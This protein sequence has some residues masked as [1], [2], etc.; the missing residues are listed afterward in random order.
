MIDGILFV[1][2][3]LL[4][5]GSIQCPI[6]QLKL[7]HNY[8]SDNLYSLFGGER[9]VQIDKIHEIVSVCKRRHSLRAAAIKNR[10]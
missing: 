5:V 9:T 3:A 1:Q 7:S 8:D 10:Y 6:A 2:S 4:S